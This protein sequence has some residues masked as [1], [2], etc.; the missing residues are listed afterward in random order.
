MGELDGELPMSPTARDDI[1][2]IEEHRE[3]LKLLAR[4][5]LGPRLRAKLDASDLVQQ[6][7]LQAHER[8]DQF[9]GRGEGE[10]L[11]W[12]RSILASTI[13][14]ALRRFETQARDAAREQSLEAELEHSAARLEVLLAADQTSPSEGA[15]RSEELLR[16][17]E[18]L[19]GLPEDQRRA[20]ELHYLAGLPVAEVAELIGRSRPAAVGLLF[21]GL[22][23]LREILNDPAESAHGA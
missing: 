3:Y 5:R 22:K 6:A 18:A 13:A 21:R 9:R 15:V 7:I 10:W 23:R 20:V 2:P 19:G 11:A 14:G 12:L 16:L 4:L 8:Q 17:A 1:R